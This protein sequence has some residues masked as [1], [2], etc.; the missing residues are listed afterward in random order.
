MKTQ[1]EKLQETIAPRLLN[2]RQSALYMGMK[3]GTF[4]NQWRLLG[5]V[6]IRTFQ[7]GNLYFDKADLDKAIARKK[8]EFY[9]SR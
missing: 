7:R 6:P 5:L 2:S 1:E 4:R 3:W 9:A 8:G